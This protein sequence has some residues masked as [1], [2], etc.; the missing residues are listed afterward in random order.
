MI[1]QG[2]SFGL[3]LVLKLKSQSLFAHVRRPVEKELIYEK[4]LIKFNDLLVDKN[5]LPRTGWHT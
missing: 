4:E 5:I 2:E 1:F 3:A